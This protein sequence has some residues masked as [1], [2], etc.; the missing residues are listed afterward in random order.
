MSNPVSLALGLIRSVKP[1][2]PQNYQSPTF[3]GRVAELVT[4]NLPYGAVSSYPSQSHPVTS[5]TG[6]SKRTPAKKQIRSTSYSHSRRNY[7]YRQ[8]RKYYRN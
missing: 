7:Y 4:Y 8:K 3:H 5:T 6:H 2:Q 1:N